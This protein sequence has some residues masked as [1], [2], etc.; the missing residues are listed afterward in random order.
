MGKRMRKL[1]D[2]VDSGNALVFDEDDN[3]D[4]LPDL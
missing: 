2:D 1:Q 4:H 3:N